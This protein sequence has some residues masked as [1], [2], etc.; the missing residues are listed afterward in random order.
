MM[1]PAL[2]SRV[3]SLFGLLALLIF[4]GA[5]AES[6]LPRAA[7]VPGGVVI[8]DLG[9][10]A[11]DP[12]QV[13]F[14]DHRVLVLEH[15]ARWSAVVGV[16]LATKPGK[17]RV[18]IEQAGAE[19]RYKTFAVGAKKYAVQRL[20]VPPA[21]VNLSK[22]DEERVARERV[23]IDAA[24]ETWSGTAPEN[25]RLA[26]PVPGTR[27]SSFGLRRVFNDEPRNPHSGMDIAADAGTP[28]QAPASGTVI[29]TGDYFFNGRTV[30]IDHGEG[31]ITMYCH[32][33]A[34]EVQPDQHVATGEVLGKVGA[35]GR[36]TGP[37]L[38]WGVSLNRAFVDPALFLSPLPATPVTT[39]SH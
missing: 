22:E 27:S 33:S 8:L 3:L 11:S 2:D 10:V 25:L 13:F 20:T 35:T 37:H 17:Q 19:P 6:A 14:N 1:R 5:R 24:L 26:Q 34:I 21:Q 23:R 32:L 7:A 12:P 31:L 28:I 38:H 4:Q 16:P 15:S 30:F 9:P 39:P 36:V 29:D 18:R